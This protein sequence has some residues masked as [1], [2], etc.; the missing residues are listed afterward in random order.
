[1]VLV[2]F[3]GAFAST[4]LL[5]YYVEVV[6]DMCPEKFNGN[7]EGQYLIR[8]IRIKATCGMIKVEKYSKGGK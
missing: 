6:L 2:I 4:P 8:N 3:S 1:M 7:S 5:L